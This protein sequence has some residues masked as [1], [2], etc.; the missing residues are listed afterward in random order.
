MIQIRPENAADGAAIRM[1]NELAFGRS[2]EADLVQALRSRYDDLISLVAEL[3]GRVV[4]HIL[5]SPMTIK[6]GAAL[7]PAIGL[8]P[9]AVLPDFQGQGIGSR[10]V[11]AGLA[12][13]QEAGY[14]LALVLGHPWF[15]PRFGFVPSAPL[16]IRWEHDVPEEVFMVRPLKEGALANRSG[17]A[18]YR[19]EFEGV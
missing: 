12:A 6:D 18:Y 10:L 19:P 13:C 7:Y 16:G 4:G 8:G 9:M 15:Y 1:V 5:F 11:E 14:E 17:I 2:Q 3:D